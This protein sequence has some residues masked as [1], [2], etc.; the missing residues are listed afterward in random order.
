M[1]PGGFDFGERVVARYLWA[2]KIMHVNYLVVS[3][4][5]LDHFGGAFFI[6][7]NFSPGE[8]WTTA[9]VK[10]EP[11][12]TAL[13]AEVAAEKIPLRI[14]DSSMRPLRLGGASVRCLGP[15]PY[16]TAS[17]DNNLSMVLRIDEPPQ[18][19][20]FTGD[21]EAAAERALLART[22]PA[23][24][25]A[26]VLKAPHH[27]SHTSSSGAF[28]AAVRP[29]VAVISLGYRNSFGFPAPEVVA[30]YLAAGARVL[31]TDQSGAVSVGLEAGAPML[32]QAY[33]FPRSW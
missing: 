2:R 14:V 7:R 1:R 21:I 26:T 31:R 33:N 15:A 13:L 20:L 28:V 24:L 30:R 16:E 23:M 4:P 10:P 32:L 27:G 17:K 18:S 19:V 9:A 8:F 3:H 22:P 11:T 5:D 12:Y 25:A 29:Q 6:A